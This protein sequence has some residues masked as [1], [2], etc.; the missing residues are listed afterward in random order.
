[1]TRH[2][3]TLK[4]KHN[5]DKTV[6]QVRIT[7]FAAFLPFDV[8]MRMVALSFLFSVTSCPPTQCHE[9][10][11]LLAEGSLRGLTW[12][13]IWTESNVTAR[14]DIIFCIQA[15]PFIHGSNPL[16]VN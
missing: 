7:G 5:I 9:L 4:V 15:M 2:F 6:C 1:M 13:F 16:P 14:I 10:I 3:I 11:A 8:Y 12:D